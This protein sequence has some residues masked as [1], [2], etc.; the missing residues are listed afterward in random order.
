MLSLNAPSVDLK[1]GCE[2]FVSSPSTEAVIG[3]DSW[4][5]QLIPA[6]TL[7]RSFH[8]RKSIKTAK[9]ISQTPAAA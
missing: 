8:S 3:L 6:E 1:N 9:D 5:I 2:K 7:E 4:Q